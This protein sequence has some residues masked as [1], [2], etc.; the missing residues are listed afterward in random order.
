MVGLISSLIMPLGMYLFALIFYVTVH[1]LRSPQTSL[2]CCLTPSALSSCVLTRGLAHHSGSVL[3]LPHFCPDL[4]KSSQVWSALP[5]ICA[6]LLSSARL[7]QV[8]PISAQLCPAEHPL[9]C[10]F[11]PFCRG[12]R[13]QVVRRDMKHNVSLARGPNIGANSSVQ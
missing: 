12:G 13:Y 1:P 5:Q 2:L 6:T 4:L 11:G 8:C 7:V 3:P 9:A 10:S